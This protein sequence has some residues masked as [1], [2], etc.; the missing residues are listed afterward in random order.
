MDDTLQR[1]G[2]FGE[3][4]AATFI[5]TLEE[6]DPVR[7]QGTGLFDCLQARELWPRV[8]ERVSIKFS[9]NDLSRLVRATERDLRSS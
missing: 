1:Y 8:D 9:F 7:D 5:I 4:P 2:W 3:S 6:R